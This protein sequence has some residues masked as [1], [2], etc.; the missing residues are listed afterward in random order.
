MLENKTMQL[1]ELR[2]VY[3]TKKRKRVGRGGKRGTYSGR[4][5]KG[6]KARAGAKI[7][8]AIRDLIIKLPKRRGLG[9][10]KPKKEFAEINLGVLN[11][12]FNEKEIVSPRTLLKKGL[13]ERSF[14]RI[15]EVKILGQ[16]N[17]EKKLIF[18]NCHFSK[19]ALEKLK[20]LKIIP[21]NE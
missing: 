16:G 1:H 4:G 18:R 21:E 20:A 15:P 7:R 5:I 2:K 14:G 6:Q 19:S 11:Q 17:L 12:Y 8:P 3:K 10:K 9:F 13:I